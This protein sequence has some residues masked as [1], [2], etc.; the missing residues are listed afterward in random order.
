[1]RCDPPGSEAFLRRTT[2]GKARNQ[3]LALVNFLRA[4]IGIG[5]SSRI[6]T[7]NGTTIRT[8]ARVDAVAGSHRRSQSL[9][10]NKGAEWRL[11]ECRRLGFL[12]GWGEKAAF[13]EYILRVGTEDFA[14]ID[15]IG[16]KIASKLWRRTCAYS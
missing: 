13:W 2:D 15:P 8:C 16:K 14:Q 7:L 9:F 10:R 5:I 11:P 3:N 12:C 6:W 1:M 4:S